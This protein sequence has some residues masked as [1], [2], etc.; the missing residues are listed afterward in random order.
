MLYATLQRRAA[1]LETL[2]RFR[3][4]LDVLAALQAVKNPDEPLPA[5]QVPADWY[6]ARA[7]GRLHLAPRQ[8]W[9][10]LR[11]FET[12]EVLR[13]ELAQTLV[14]LGLVDLDLSGIVGPKRQLT[15][16]IT[17]WAYVH[18]YVALVYSSRYDAALTCWAIFSHPVDSAEILEPMGHSR[19]LRCSP[20]LA[21]RVSWATSSEPS[22]VVQPTRLPSRA[23]L[24]VTMVAVFRQGDRVGLGA[25]GVC[26]TPLRRS[27]YMSSISSVGGPAR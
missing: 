18:G 12:R 27:R 22:G 10:D 11:S 23:C 4:S 26:E 7:V 19:P 1:F 8:R 3:P 17:R 24:S 14:D 2:V 15:Q 5:P 20:V 21:W 25:A 9:L 13:R 6:G 16:T